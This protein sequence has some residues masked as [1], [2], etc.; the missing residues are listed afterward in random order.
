M[1]WRR[2]FLLA[3]VNLLTAIPLIIFM[4]W[5]DAR[6]TKAQ[7][8]MDVIFAAQE[9]AIVAF[10]PCKLWVDFPVQEQVVQF[11]NFPAFI[12]T[13]WQTECPPRWSVA[14]MLQ[15]NNA[16]SAFARSR[17]Q[18]RIDL[19]FCL[20]IALQ[21]L[22]L[23]SFPHAVRTSRWREPGM[24]ISL[25]TALAACLALIPIVS[26]LA[27][28]PALFAVLGWFYWACVAFAKTL[29]FAWKLAASPLRQ[30]LSL[31]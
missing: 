19:I 27:R 10:D 12:V 21:W 30:R 6:Y 23:G 5:M 17:V 14:G 11:G 3:A 4:E 25:C 28:L 31:R 15:I 1:Q 24:F 29:R 26:P 8:K 16:S 2:G 7:L 9:S 13:S 22:L 18:R 20:L